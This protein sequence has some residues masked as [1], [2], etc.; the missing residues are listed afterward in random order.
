MKHK[1]IEFFGLPGVGK[2][3]FEIEV[4]RYLKLK[5]KTVL[6]RR[7]IITKYAFTNLKINFLDYTS[8]VYFGFVEK[9]KNKRKKNLE[10]NFVPKNFKKKINL[11]IVF[12]IF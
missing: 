10:N 6:N 9:L 5:N 12:Q 7:E 1:I 4:K 3:T 11:R 2:T 8:L